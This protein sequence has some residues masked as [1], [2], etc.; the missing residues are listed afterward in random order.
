MIPIAFQAFLLTPQMAVA[1]LTAVVFLMVAVAEDLVPFD[2][3]EKKTRIYGFRSFFASPKR[4]IV[5][6]S[7]YFRYNR[8]DREIEEKSDVEMDL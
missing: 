5:E 8:T 3:R 7:A 2:S 6:K 1:A 4:S